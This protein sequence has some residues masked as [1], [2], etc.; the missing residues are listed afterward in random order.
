MT[1]PRFY[2]CENKLC[3]RRL[4]ELVTGPRT[5][6]F[7]DACR[8]FG[9][10]CREEGYAGGLASGVRL[11]YSRAAVVAGVCALLIAVAWAIVHFW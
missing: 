4:A 1:A 2:H 9:A 5:E 10:K 7:C 11:G 3:R 6:V 8:T